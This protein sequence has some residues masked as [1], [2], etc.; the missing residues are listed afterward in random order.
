MLPAPECF[1]DMFSY[2]FFVATIKSI[3][4]TD[5]SIFLLLVF[6]KTFVLCPIPER[7]NSSRKLLK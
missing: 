3:R 2:F 6:I 1:Q 4:L 5:A 7:P